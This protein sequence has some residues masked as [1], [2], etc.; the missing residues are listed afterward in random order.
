MTSETET[1]LREALALQHED[2]AD[3]AAQLLASLDSPAVDDPAT[4][5]AAWAAEL[6]RRA[7]RVLS[8]AAPTVDWTTV[9]DRV[10]DQLDG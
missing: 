9:R 3:L 4:I 6:E 2:R 10:A 7:A 5:G 8:G 1:I